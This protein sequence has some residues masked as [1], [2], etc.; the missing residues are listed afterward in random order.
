MTFRWADI[1]ASAGTSFAYHFVFVQ[2]LMIYF[3]FSKLSH[4]IG[5]LLSKMVVRS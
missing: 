1:P 4:T 3:P 5:T 2:I